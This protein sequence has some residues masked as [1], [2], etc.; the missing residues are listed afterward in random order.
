MLKPVGGST[1]A[2]EQP[3]PRGRRISQWEGPIRGIVV[4][5][6]VYTFKSAY[7]TTTVTIN[8][9]MSRSAKPGE[10]STGVWGLSYVGYTVR[11][12]QLV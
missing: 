9:S 5:H 11:M 4:I 6:K 2:A 10:G 1:E 3:P 8:E 12:A 7:R